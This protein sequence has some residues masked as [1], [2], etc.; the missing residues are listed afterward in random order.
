MSDLCRATTSS[1]ANILGNFISREFTVALQY[2]KPCKAPGPDSICPELILH[3]R[4][5][6]K[7]WLYGFLSSCLRRLKISKIWR[8]ALVVAIPKPKKPENSKSYPPISL[9]CVL[10]NI[11]EWLIHTRV[12][13]IIDPKFPMEQAGFQHGK[14]T[15]HQTVLLP[16]NIEDSFE[17]KKKTDAVLVDLTAAYDTVWHRGLTC[18]L[19][20]LLPDKYRFG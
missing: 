12:E 16:Q 19:L 2:L 7:S 17:A 18:K 4:A 9:L 3:A 5:A 8:R 6:L 13:P 1:S 11:I 15:V 10:F 14:S 20:K